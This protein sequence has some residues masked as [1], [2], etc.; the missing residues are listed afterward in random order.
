MTLMKLSDNYIPIQKK[1]VSAECWLVNFIPPSLK[2][3]FSLEKTNKPLH[4]PLLKII[5]PIHEVTSQKH[6]DIYLSNNGT[7]HEHISYIYT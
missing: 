2:L 7:W 1:Y 5:E 4:P 6:L 3:Y